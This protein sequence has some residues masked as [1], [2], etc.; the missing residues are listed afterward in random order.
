MD[1]TLLLAAAAVA[2]A[3]ASFGW[4]VLTVHRHVW[5]YSLLARLGDRPS[6]EETTRTVSARLSIFEAFRDPVDVVF[7][8]DSITASAPLSEMFPGVRLANRGIGGQT[9]RDFLRRLDGVI[10][11]KPGV[12]YIMGGVNSAGREEVSEAVAALEAILERLAAAGIPVV[13]QTTLEPRGDRRSFVQALNVEIRR[14]AVE[15]VDLAPMQDEGGVR[16]EYTYDGTHLNGAGY[17]AWQAVLEPHVRRYA[18]KPMLAPP[19]PAPM[20]G[21]PTP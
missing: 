12:V 1:R 17:R 10:A 11:L 4:G 3:A 8:G 14:V 19:S 7:L 18:G 20:H 15:V 16:A 21:E 2:I 13:L 5:P 9:F 6:A